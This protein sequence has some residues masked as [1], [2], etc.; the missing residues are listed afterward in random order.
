MRPASI[1]STTDESS[2]SYPDRMDVVTLEWTRRHRQVRCSTILN[3]EEIQHNKDSLTRVASNSVSRVVYMTTVLVNLR[4]LTAT[5]EG[6]LWAHKKAA[7]ESGLL[8]DPSYP[9]GVRNFLNT[10][11]SISYLLSPVAD[12]LSQQAVF[13]AAQQ[14]MGLLAM[15]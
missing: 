13:T 6:E 4:K 3:G 15:I 12:P 5:L 11:P 10:D 2:R 14:V 7:Q 1:A 8:L 9:S